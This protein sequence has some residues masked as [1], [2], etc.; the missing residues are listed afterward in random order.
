LLVNTSGFEGGTLR[1]TRT[2]PDATTVNVRATDEP[3]T[4]TD[5]QWLDYDY[6]A[7]F[8]AP[9]TY[10]AIMTLGSSSSSADTV[11]L[12]V[13]R[14]WL[15]HAGDP[16]R[17]YSPP[18]V[19]GFAERE[20]NVDQGSFKVLGR[21]DPVITTDGQRSGVESKVMIRTE[22][23]AE[24][25]GLWAVLEDGSTLLLNVPAGFGWGL[26]TEWIAVGKVGEAR[27][28]E[29]RGADQGR[30]FTLPYMVAPRP[31]GSVLPERVYADLPGEA[32]TYSYQSVLYASYLDLRSGTQS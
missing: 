30:I 4:I 26:T 14:V 23:H 9:V 29:L 25:D 2:D 31:V 20:R 6:E 19:R 32:S 13:G 7:P 8:G 5:S 18:R 10:T 15:I 17:S 16:S 3:I 1:V 21:R 11:T 12:D 27:V 28:A 24:R 22:T